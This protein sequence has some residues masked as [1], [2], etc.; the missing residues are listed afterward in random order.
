[1]VDCR[2]CVVYVAIE[3]FIQK[4]RQELELPRMSSSWTVLQQLLLGL[5]CAVQL[6]AHV[7]LSA[8]A[9]QT[10]SPEVTGILKSATLAAAPPRYL[11]DIQTSQEGTT[12]QEKIRKLSFK[13]HLC[14]NTLR[15][16][17]C[18]REHHLAK[19]YS[20]VART[21]DTIIFHVCCKR[22]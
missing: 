22:L 13:P 4:R 18:D 10:L 1:M 7:L 2:E 6:R 15:K 17:P 14:L 19:L 11:A 8:Q 16:C 3:K 12:I 5:S 20:W 9:K 21:R